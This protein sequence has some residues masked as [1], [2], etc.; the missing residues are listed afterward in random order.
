MRKD[1]TFILLRAA[2]QL[3]QH[4]LLERLLSPHWF[5]SASPWKY[6]R[7][8]DVR[9]YSCI[10]SLIPLASLPLLCVPLCPDDCSH[11]VSLY[12]GQCESC[13]IVLSKIVLA[14]LGPFCFHVNFRSIVSV[15]EKRY[16]NFWWDLH[17]ICR[18]VWKVLPSSWC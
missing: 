10:L 12:A 3:S 9:I 16:L 7:T 6:Q 5:V 2:I 17:W 4:D 15:T 13:S 1:S 14:L 11:V 18:P 8:R